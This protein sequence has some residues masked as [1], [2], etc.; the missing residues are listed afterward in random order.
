M[1]KQDI[2]AAIGFR[3]VFD[4]L[5]DYNKPVCGHNLFLDIGHTLDKF[6]GNIPESSEE[7]KKRTRELF[8]M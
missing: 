7:F 8:P 3:R 4:L 1:K 2:N 6:D 5:K